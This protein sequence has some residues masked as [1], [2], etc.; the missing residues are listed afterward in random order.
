M[1]ELE[2]FK[3]YFGEYKIIKNRG[4]MMEQQ[5]VFTVTKKIQIVDV[6]PSGDGLR[7]SVMSSDGDW[8]STFNQTTGKQLEGISEDDVVEIKYVVNKKGFSNFNSIKLVDDS[9]LQEKAPGESQPELPPIEKP[10]R[11]K[12][13]NCIVKQ[14]TG[15]IAAELMKSMDWSKISNDEIMGRFRAIWQI[16]YE[17]CIK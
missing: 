16:I 15:K 2:L 5:Q 6:K 3:K 14:S 7:Y 11:T 1:K 9:E 8:F 12:D 13:Q 4:E 17:E 10:K